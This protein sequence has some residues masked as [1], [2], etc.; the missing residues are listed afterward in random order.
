MAFLY[1]TVRITVLSSSP[2]FLLLI[3][4][5]FV[6]PLPTATPVRA[7]TDQKF[8]E[9]LRKI[10]LK[11]ENEINLFATQSTFFSRRLLLKKTS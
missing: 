1:F 6:F 10:L 9:K 2:C 11:I 8:I 3:L 7:K 4:L 5:S